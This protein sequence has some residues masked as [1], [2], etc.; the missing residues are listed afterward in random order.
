MK[1]SKI[2]VVIIESERGWGR[3]V[4]SVKYF[5]TH[6]AA[7]KFVAKYNQKNIDDWE[8]TH[9]VPDWYMVAQIE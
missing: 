3:K 6:K 8:K 5:P 7:E 1:K 2:K 4:N 9:T